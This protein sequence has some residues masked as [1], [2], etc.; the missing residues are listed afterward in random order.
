MR[1]KLT[2]KSIVHSK[3]FPNDKKH[4]KAN[5]DHDN[6]S[7]TES[8]GV[9]EEKEEV[10]KEDLEAKMISQHLFHDALPIYDVSSCEQSKHVEDT[11]AKPEDDQF[12]VKK[13]EPYR[14]H[15]NMRGQN[16]VNRKLLNNMACTHIFRKAK[17]IVMDTWHQKKNSHG[18][19]WPC[20]SSPMKITYGWLDNQAA[21]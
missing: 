2:L 17:S 18:T 15:T 7:Q 9:P 20:A 1:K 3:Q 16:L 12:K 19:G 6:C 10:R 21:R 8:S 4:L 13:V 5:E 14:P 11:V